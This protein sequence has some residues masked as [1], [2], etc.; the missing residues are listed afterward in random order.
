MLDPCNLIGKKF[1]CICYIANM[2][3]CILY[4][5]VIDEPENQLIS[6]GL[7]LDQEINTAEFLGLRME[8]DS[9]KWNSI[10]GLLIYLAGY[11]KPDIAYAANCCA[12]CMI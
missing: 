3:F 10:V 8:T 1:I 12:G 4:E 9:T 11:T 6:V 5:S 2:I 7:L